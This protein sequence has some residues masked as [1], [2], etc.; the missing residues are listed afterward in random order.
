[1][2]WS[3]EIAAAVTPGQL[4][5]IAAIGLDSITG[6]HGH[7]GRGDDVAHDAE[8]RQLSVKDIPA[9]PCLVTD[10]ELRP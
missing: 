3:T 5:R 10:A 1:M 6:F 8:R 9:R 2:P 7:E 4:Y